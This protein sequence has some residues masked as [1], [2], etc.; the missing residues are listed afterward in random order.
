MT[1]EDRK[2][3]LRKDSPQPVE[4]DYNAHQQNPGPSPEAVEEKDENG[5]GLALKWVI[6]IAVIALLIVWF[7]FFREG[8]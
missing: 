1:S 2:E 4:H 8:M 3:Q 5:G 7:F 6:P